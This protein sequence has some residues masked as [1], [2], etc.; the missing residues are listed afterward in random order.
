VPVV[1]P[2]KGLYEIGTGHDPLTKRDLSKGERAVAALATV[3]GVVPLGK[4]IVGK[5]LKALVELGGDEAVETA[6]KQSDNIGGSSAK[7]TSEQA[8]AQVE[9]A[10]KSAPETV[11]RWMSRAE[12]DATEASGLLRGG[13]DG[14]HYVTDAANSS[15]QRARLRTALPQTTEVRVTL[16]VPGGTFSP[17]TRVQ[18]AF[19]MPGGGME[20][21]ATGQIPV[22]ILRVDGKP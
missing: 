19:G 13:R 9:Q 16:E 4:T 11:Q 7:V 2:I 1:G 22:R 15:A 18:Q 14:T 17:P 10:A 20:R 12:L 5:G 8:S 6:V 21:T 3:A